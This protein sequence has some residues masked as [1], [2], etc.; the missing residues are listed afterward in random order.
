MPLM[1]HCEYN[2]DGSTRILAALA[3][4]RKV[5]VWKYDARSWAALSPA[6]GVLDLSSKHG[7]EEVIWYLEYVRDEGW[8]WNES[9]VR[10]M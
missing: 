8:G 4:G 3:I 7:Q 6:P 10:S 5:K 1:D 9:G 2:K